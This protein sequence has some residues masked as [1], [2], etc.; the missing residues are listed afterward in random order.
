MKDIEKRHARHVRGG[1]SMQ[2]TKT[3]ITNVH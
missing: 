1:S 3:S 2:I